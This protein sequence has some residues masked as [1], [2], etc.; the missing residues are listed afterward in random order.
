MNEKMYV[1]MYVYNNMYKNVF[2]LVRKCF[3]TRKLNHLLTGRAGLALT[4]LIR[5]QG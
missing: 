4:Q 2:F 1:C 3:F 5:L